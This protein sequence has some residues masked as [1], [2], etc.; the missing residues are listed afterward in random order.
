MGLDLIQMSENALHS[1][2]PRS[3]PP[4]EVPDLSGWILQDSMIYIDGFAIGNN[5]RGVTTTDFDRS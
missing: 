3:R 4:D 1:T 5:D 2:D